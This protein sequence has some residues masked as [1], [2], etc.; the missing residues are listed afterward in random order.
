MRSP[1][2]RRKEL[3]AVSTSCS[4]CVALSLQSVLQGAAQLVS[5]ALL[6]FR[7]VNHV[8]GGDGGEGAVCVVADWVQ[9]IDPVQSRSQIQQAGVRAACGAVCGPVFRK[10]RS[11]WEI[12]GQG[13]GRKKKLSR[14]LS[15][16]RA[17]SSPAGDGACCHT[18][19]H[20]FV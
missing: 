17:G 20:C 8:V 9:R 11:L 13:R 6:V 4:V 3:A 10:E 12:L 18:H 2:K 1:C 15:I 5:R 19:H 7:S 14:A 16:E